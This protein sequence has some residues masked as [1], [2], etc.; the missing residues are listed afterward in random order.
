[1][2]RLKFIWLKEKKLYGKV[3]TDNNKMVK[4]GLKWGGGVVVKITTR[5]EKKLFITSFSGGGVISG[6]I[7]Q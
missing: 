2:L 7:L 3:S 4:G 6:K 1:M 5:K